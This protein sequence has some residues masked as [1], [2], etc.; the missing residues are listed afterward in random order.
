MV[1]TNLLPIGSI[2]QKEDSKVMI[3]GYQQIS[4][5]NHIVN[6]YC[7]VP[8]PF[9]FSQLSDVFI[10]RK[11]AADQVV[12]KG[13]EDNALYQSYIEDKQLLFDSSEGMEVDKVQKAIDAIMREEI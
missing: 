7:V 11:E 12:F 9:G 10:I 13:Y 2:I 4:E 5:D 3:V 8:F 6:C 1:R